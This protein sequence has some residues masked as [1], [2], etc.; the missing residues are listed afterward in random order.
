MKL[1][2]SWLDVCWI[3]VF[4]VL[5]LPVFLPWA[6]FVLVCD[7]FTSDQSKESHL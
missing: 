1:R 6:V 5:A 7:R 3:S 2:M 4:F